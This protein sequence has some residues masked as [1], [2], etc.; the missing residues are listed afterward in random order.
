MITAYIKERKKS[1]NKFEN[2]KIKF[3]YIVNK[4]DIENI[5]DKTIY[6]LPI[7]KENKLSK[8]KTKKLVNRLIKMLDEIWTN[9]VVLSESLSQNEL[10]KNCLYSNN[11]NILNG[12]FLFK[13]LYNNII[14]YIL[15]IK[16]E[17]IQ[18]NQIWITV[19]DFTTINK[20]IIID[21]GKRVKRLNIVTNNIDKCKDIESYLYNEYGIVLNISNNKNISLSKAKIIL[22]LDFPQ[23]LINKYKINTKAIIINILGNIEIKSKK[24][25]GINVNNYNINIPKQYQLEGFKNEEVYESIVYNLNFNEIQERLNKDKIKIKYLIGNRGIINKIEFT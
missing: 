24:F 13:N 3:K 12:R 1:K 18:S 2:I 15:N 19:N 10:F 25:S 8:Y 20:E 7:F 11:I 17:E 9:K 14:E 22:N 6:Y 5:E 4:I 21:I 16:K 23:E